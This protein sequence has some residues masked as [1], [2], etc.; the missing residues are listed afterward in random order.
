MDE[1]QLL[2]SGFISTKKPNVFCEEITV[3]KFTLTAKSFLVLKMNIL[4]TFV[5]Q[6]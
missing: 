5:T 1:L 6:L 4:V 3:H 2:L